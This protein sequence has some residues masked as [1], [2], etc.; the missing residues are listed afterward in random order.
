MRNT[1][2]F[3]ALLVVLVGIGSLGFSEEA[4]IGKGIMDKAQLADILIAG[5]PSLDP[6]FA[7]DFAALYILEAAEEGVNHDVAFTQMCLETGYLKFDGLVTLESN[8]F[9]G[10]GVIDTQ[11]RGATFPSVLLGVRAHIQ[12]L[13]GY[14]T[15]EPLAQTRVD[16]RYYNIFHGSAPTLSDLTGRW[17]VNLAYG[18]ALHN[19]LADHYLLAFGHTRPEL[20][21]LK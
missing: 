5:N 21:T 7:Q 12:H 19:L 4:I 14:A 13:K 20:V 17:S 15:K 6:S 2:F 11:K 1:K 16:P 3:A 10:I 18:D 8:N 9:G